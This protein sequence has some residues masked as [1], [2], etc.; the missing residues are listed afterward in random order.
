MI[1]FIK[2]IIE[3]PEKF[4]EDEKY[5]MLLEVVDKKV[6]AEELA[7]IITFIKSKQ[8]IKIDLPN[9]INIMNKNC[10]TLK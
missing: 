8:A 9:A 7:E 5:E 2:K 10:K 4:S 6:E 1:N 3:N